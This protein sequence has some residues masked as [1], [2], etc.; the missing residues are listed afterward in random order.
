MF[1]FNFLR[2]KNLKTVPPFQT[3]TKEA[4]PAKLTKTLQDMRSCKLKNLQDHSSIY[5]TLYVNILKTHV[6]IIRQRFVL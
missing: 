4:T 6:Y 2:T 3:L 5:R 1:S